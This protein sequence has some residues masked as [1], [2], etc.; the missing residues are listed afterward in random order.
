MLRQVSK[1]LFHLNLKS[2]MSSHLGIETQ[3]CHQD[4]N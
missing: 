2:L 4:Y 3:A 1:L